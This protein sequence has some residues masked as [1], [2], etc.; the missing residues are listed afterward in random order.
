MRN[1]LFII[2]LTTTAFFAQAQ[3]MQPNLKI[4]DSKVHTHTMPIKIDVKE[5]AT[6][7]IKASAVSGIFIMKHSRVK[8]A[9]SFT[10]KTK[11]PKLV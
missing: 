6:N 11:T 7:Q 4:I 10:V 2:F 8:R 1:L 9:L 3:D 5:I